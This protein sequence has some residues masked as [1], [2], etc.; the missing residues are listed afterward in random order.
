[1][2]SRVM[3][4]YQARFCE[5]FRG[6]TPLYLLDQPTP[7]FKIKTNYSSLSSSKSL[8]VDQSNS[9]L[10]ESAVEVLSFVCLTNLVNLPITDSFVCLYSVNSLFKS[11]ISRLNDSFSSRKG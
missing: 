4:D 8:Y 11:L 7:L 9:L 1:M 6:E 10:L 3:G 5:R 2:K